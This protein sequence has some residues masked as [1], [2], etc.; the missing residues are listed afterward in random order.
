MSTTSRVDYIHH[1]IMKSLT[2]EVIV[3]KKVAGEANKVAK[4]LGEVHTRVD[5]VQTL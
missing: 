1:L 2:Q 3:A 5:K 4:I